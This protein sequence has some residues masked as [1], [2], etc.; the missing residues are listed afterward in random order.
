MVVSCEHSREQRPLSVSEPVSAFGTVLSTW[1]VAVST[2]IVMWALHGP[3]CHLSRDHR[4]M[5]FPVT[6][7]PV[8]YPC[9]HECY[10][11]ATQH[12]LAHAMLVC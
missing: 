8:V 10:V 4:E 11:H 2:G 7:V 3:D 1:C 6:E 9:D 12:T 5:L